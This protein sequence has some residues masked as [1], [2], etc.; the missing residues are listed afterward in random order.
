MVVKYPL[1]EKIIFLRKNSFRPE[2]RAGS[3]ELLFCLPEFG[4]RKMKQTIRKCQHW[5]ASAARQTIAEVKKAIRP[6][7][8]RQQK[9]KQMAE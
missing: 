4:K 1:C 2:I 9:A 8:Q 7:T 5:I 3:P 6:R